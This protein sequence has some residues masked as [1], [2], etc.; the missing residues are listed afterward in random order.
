MIEPPYSRPWSNCKPKKQRWQDFRPTK[1][2]SSDVKG[3][4]CLFSVFQLERE[5]SRLMATVHQLQNE[6]ANAIANISQAELRASDLQNRLALSEQQLSTTSRFWLWWYEHRNN[7]SQGIPPMAVFD[8]F[9]KRKF[10]NSYAIYGDYA[11]L[12]CMF[13]VPWL[14]KPKSAIVTIK[15]LFLTCDRSFRRRNRRA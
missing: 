4:Y 15:R 7:I 6:K 2:S 1:R 5:R 12:Q 10:H 9:D 3:F 14:V 13:T 11:M 8:D